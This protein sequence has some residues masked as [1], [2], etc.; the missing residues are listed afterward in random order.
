MNILLTGAFGN[1]G[2]SALDELLRC[3]YPVRCFDVHT[4]ANEK[5]ARPYQGRVEIQWGD[6]RHPQDVDTAVEGQDVAL[7]LAFVIPRLS[8]TGVNCEDR[9]DWAR[10]INVGGTR[11][12]IEAIQKLRDRNP[13]ANPRLLFTSSLHVYGRTQDRT[14][15]RT[16]DETPQP[17]E[18][19]AHHKVE[20][21][22]LVRASGLEWCIFRLGAA[23][24]IRLVTDPGMFDVPLA[25][26]IEYV[27]TRDVGLAIANALAAPVWGKI[28]HIGGGAR[29]QLYYREMMDKV[30]NATGIGSLPERAFTGV[31]FSTDWLDTQ[32]SQA[33]LRFQRYTLDDYAQELRAMLGGLRAV[34]RL[35]RPAVRAW[36]LSTSPYA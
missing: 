35:F 29:C 21:E 13:A 24:P 14:P 31:P 1:V 2:R 18:N 30:L 15:P 27:H 8:V 33:L 12:L 25:N 19:Y 34:I 5:A 16:V 36:L 3:G 26:R 17:V 7:H 28:L 10:E 22:Q 9:P 11:N 23:L 32:E 6:L 20:C 4:P